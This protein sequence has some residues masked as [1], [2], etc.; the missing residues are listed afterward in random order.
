MFDNQ[1]ALEWNSRLQELVFIN[2][3]KIDDLQLK[4][5]DHIL[6]NS[7]V[8]KELIYITKYKVCYV[9][10]LNLNENNRNKRS[11]RFF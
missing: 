8:N 4:A 11:V 1:L 6:R 9:G 5:L 10:E 2:A 7:Q 3:S